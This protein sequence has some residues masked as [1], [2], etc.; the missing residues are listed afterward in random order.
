MLEGPANI[1]NS[2]LRLTFPARMSGVL[3]KRNGEAGADGALSLM[4]YAGAVV[5]PF[6]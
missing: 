6:N 1:S 3:K 5:S 4:R 2:F